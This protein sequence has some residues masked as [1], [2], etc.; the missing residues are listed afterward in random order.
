MSELTVII[1]TWN[2]KDLLQGCLQSLQRQRVPC[3][4]RVVDNGSK[5]S[6]EEMV[7]S[8][9]PTFSCSL[10]Y[11]NLGFNRGFAEAAN[12]GIRSASTEFVALLNNDTETDRGWV[13]TGIA[14]LHQYPDYAIFASRI[15]DYRRRDQL[16]SA[17]D[18]YDRGGIPY[19]RGRGQPKDRFSEIEPVL[20]ASAAA[21]FYRRSLFDEIGFFDEDFFMYLEDVD[22]CLR[23]QVAG[24]CCLYLPDAIV[25][26]MEAASDPMAGRIDHR[27]GQGSEGNSSTVTRSGEYSRNRAYWITRNRWQLMITYQPLRHVVWLVYGWVR[28]GFSHLFKAGF[29]GSFLS[30]FLAGLWATPRALSKRFALSKTR[31]ISMRQ[32][33]ELL[34]KC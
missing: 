13:E 29:L 8:I 12:V 15:I 23:A 3:Q 27:H 34:K 31:T 11:V 26:H 22:F 33:R 24:H 16:D 2:Q 7:E 9:Q 30:G 32:F 10:Q 4:V 1:P 14:A 18:C 17:G 28:S 6:T 5:D 21:A 25:Y 19:K 20:A